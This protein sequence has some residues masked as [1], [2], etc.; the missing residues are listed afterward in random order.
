MVAL[1][2]WGDLKLGNCFKLPLYLITYYFDFKTV[3]LGP[4]DKQE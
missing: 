2:L 1:N 3:L 4:Q